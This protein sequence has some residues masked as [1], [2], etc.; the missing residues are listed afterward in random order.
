MARVIRY[1]SNFDRKAFRKI[2]RSLIIT[3]CTILIRLVRSYYSDSLTE[4]SFFTS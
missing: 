2:G 3:Y 4:N 1:I